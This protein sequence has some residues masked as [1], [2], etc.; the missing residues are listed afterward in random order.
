M[1]ADRL[2]NRMVS[3]WKERMHNEKPKMDE[4]EID[5]LANGADVTSYSLARL[6][7]RF[8]IKLAF[9]DG[10]EPIV[11]ALNPVVGLAIS[12]GII[13]AGSECGWVSFEKEGLLNVHP[14]H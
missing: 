5:D 7:D 14:E 3:Y 12:A 13:G 10:R 4:S 9:S 1:S 11:V 6:Q 8:L 2:T